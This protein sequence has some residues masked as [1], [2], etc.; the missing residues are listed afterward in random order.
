MSTFHPFPLLTPELRTQ[1]FRLATTP[2]RTIRIKESS[3]GHGVYSPTPP[4]P[5]TRVNREARQH[6]AYKRSFTSPSGRYVWVDFTHDTIHVRSIVFWNLESLP[7]ADIRHLR[8]ELIDERGEEVIEDWWHHHLPL[9]PKFTSL[10]SVDLLVPRELRYYAPQYIE[11][12]YFGEK[13]ARENVRIVRMGSGEWIDGET[14]G[15]YADW[16]ESF[17][18]REEEGMTR[19]VDW[20]VDGETRRERMEDVR[21][22]EMPRP[23]VRL[24]YP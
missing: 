24:D 5:I 23:R 12:A 18:G 8:I 13:C 1:I 4:P 21:A 17:G 11:D 10:Q 3:S 6:S 2:D 20:D 19:V 15:V 9:L 16:V 14:A 22:L 7:L